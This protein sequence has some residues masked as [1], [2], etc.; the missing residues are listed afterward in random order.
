MGYKSGNTTPMGYAMFQDKTNTSLKILSQIN[1][2]KTAFNIVNDTLKTSDKIYNA[3]RFTLLDAD[4]NMIYFILG[5]D[6]YSRNLTNKFEQLQFSVP[7]GEEITF[8]R[9]R[10]YTVASDLPFNYNYVM[11]GTKVGDGYKVRMFTKSSGNLSS[12]PV[13]T[14][15]GKGIVRDVMYIAPSVSES[16]YNNTF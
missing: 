13:F 14:L 2:S 3:S 10:K 6:V 11:V 4:E 7:V 9:H 16:T 15:E 12:T 1:P 8:I 5:N